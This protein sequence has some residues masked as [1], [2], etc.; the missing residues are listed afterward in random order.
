MFVCA[1]FLLVA[2]S[3]LLVHANP[4][5]EPGYGRNYIRSYGRPHLPF[6]SSYGGNYYGSAKKIHYQY[7]RKPAVYNHHRYTY[8]VLPVIQP[9]LA[10]EAAPPLPPPAA[11]PAAPAPVPFEEPR[12]EAMMMKPDIISEPVIAEQPVPVPESVPAEPIFLNQVDPI[13][14]QVMDQFE[15]R[16]IIIPPPNALPAFPAVPVA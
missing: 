6:G 13:E 2:T 5:P 3:A 1:G 16:S 12:L 15:G 11:A 9:H 7:H 10:K 4:E 14:P 8:K